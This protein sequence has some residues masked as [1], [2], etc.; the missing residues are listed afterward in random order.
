M[1]YLLSLI[2]MFLSVGAFAEPGFL[3][4]TYGESLA[5][6][7]DGTYTSDKNFFCVLNFE[8]SATL[9]DL[10]Y[11]VVSSLDVTYIQAELVTWGDYFPNWIKNTSKNSD[12]CSIAIV[13]E[14]SNPIVSQCQII[15]YKKN[16]GLIMDSY[17][18]R[19]LFAVKKSSFDS[20]LKNNITSFALAPLGSSNMLDGNFIL[21]P[22]PDESNNLSTTWFLSA[23][24]SK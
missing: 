11:I 12:K 20:L 2:L 16:E 7:E 1:K 21:I 8:H 5:H 14:S 24:K 13:I 4:G 23:K 6:K 19:F 18:I 15:N 22:D 9:T 17:T 10:E 3:S